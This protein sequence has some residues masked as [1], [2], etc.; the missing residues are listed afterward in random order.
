MS[1]EHGA[2]ESVPNYQPTSGYLIE[3]WRVYPL[4]NRMIKHAS[5][6]LVEHKV[7]EVLC[8]LVENRERAVSRQELM[9]T[10]WPGT[11]V[12]E[13]ALSRCVSQ[14]R[15][16]FD[17]N[18]KN[19]HVIQTLRKTGYRFIA[20]VEKVRPGTGTASE[21][22]TFLW[23]WGQSG[24]RFLG[25]LVPACLFSLF[26]MGFALTQFNKEGQPREKAAV[27]QPLTAAAGLEIHPSWSPDG[28]RLA[29]IKRLPGLPGSAVYQVTPG[30]GLPLQITDGSHG[31]SCPTWSPDGRTIAFLRATERGTEL[32]LVAASGGVVRSLAMIPHVLQAG[33][34]WSPDGASI[35]L[36]G[37]PALGESFRIQV[38]NI[39]TGTL[40]DLT[41]PG[42]EHWGDF[43]PCFSPDG[44]WLSFTR[45]VNPGIQEVFVVELAGG[46]EWQVTRDA[47]QV[48]GHGWSRDSRFL[49]YSSTLSVPESLWRISR[50]GGTPQWLGGIGR[51]PALARQTGD[52]AVERWRF[53]R[54]LV[55][56]DLT[57]SKDGENQLPLLNSTLEDRD[58]KIHPDGDWI[59]FV[60]N[61]SGADQLY[62]YRQS[63]Q[64]VK[65]LTHFGGQHLGS[66]AWS[67]DGSA[68]SFASYDLAGSADIYQLSFPQGRMERLTK[69]PWNQ[70]GPSWA[71]DGK[72]IVY[73]SNQT[74]RWEIWQLDLTTGNTEQLTQFGGYRANWAPHGDALYFTKFDQPGIWKM[75]ES[76][77]G[78]QLFIEHHHLLDSGNWHVGE[79]GIFYVERKNMAATPRLMFRGFSA[80]TSRVLIDPLL[81]P[82]GRDSISLSGDET[83]LLISKTFE[84]Q[85]DLYVLPRSGSGQ[86]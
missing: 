13:E 40:S 39:A 9:E 49:I 66:P 16:L 73:G 84:A 24:R 23:P 69:D 27:W 1:H 18:S 26:L 30:G 29:Y 80:K 12:T 25:W 3:G 5:E 7:M 36:S 11:Y 43:A 52:L 57:G 8:Y 47:R 17:D 31:D 51:N 6:R 45:G 64:N 85:C 86:F 50:D 37:K 79:Q 54:G 72:A 28:S 2:Q 41:H 82:S 59:V 32:M 19:P 77:T 63:E 20:P 38:V 76:G 35:A 70:I 83:T 75:P 48:K 56:K 65:A 34:S 68:L 22:R 44:R 55:M 10:I 81:V 67:K 61:R 21:K 58:G 78:E 60:S 4:Q 14:L 71:P 15:K 46:E 74:G 33:I 42:N 53:N 62:A